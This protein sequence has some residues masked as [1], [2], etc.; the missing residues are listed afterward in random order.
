MII[1]LLLLALAASALLPVHAGIK[2]QLRG[3][4]ACI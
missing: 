2:A 3:S 1:P 4:T